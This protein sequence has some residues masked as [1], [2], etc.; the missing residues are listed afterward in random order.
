MLHEQAH[1]CDPCSLERL[2]MYAY[3]L[4]VKLHEWRILWLEAPL[5]HMVTSQLML[6]IHEC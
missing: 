4:W 6:L 2:S 5:E 3:A 1:T